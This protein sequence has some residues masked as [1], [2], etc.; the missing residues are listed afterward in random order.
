MRTRVPLLL[1][2]VAVLTLGAGFLIPT[3]ANAVDCCCTTV[4]QK[5]CVNAPPT[6]DGKCPAGAVKETSTLPSCFAVEAAARQEKLEK[7][8]KPGWVTA[9]IGE[10]LIP[11]SCRVGPQAR[12]TDCTFS[13]LLQLVVNVTRLILGV[14]GTLALAM[15][16][17]GGFLLLLSGGS[18]QRVDTARQTLINATIGLGV[19]FLSWT[20]VNFLLTLL[21]GSQNYGGGANVFGGPWN[22]GAP[23]PVAP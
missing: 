10:E 5:R 21:T 23:P 2:F 9:I 15:F 16:V 4:G 19:I 8:L 12:A 13:H 14:V 1:T 11:A 6:T 18:A 3:P 22:S 20:I 17:Y 7:D